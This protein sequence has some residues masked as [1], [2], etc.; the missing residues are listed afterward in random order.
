MSHPII[1]FFIKRGCSI[2]V[3]T[4]LFI[5]NEFVDS[6]D[7]KRFETINPATEKV[8]T[9]VAEALGNDVDRAVDAATE[10]Y[11]NVWKK[12]D[13]SERGR[14]LNKLADLLE[15]DAEEIA[16]LE[17]LDNGKAFS[18]AKALD[19]PISVKAFRYFAGYADKI[20][21]KVMLLYAGEISKFDF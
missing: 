6:I 18:T 4:C 7:G 1:F 8:I 20:H 14:L 15:R 21:G 9:T 13:G 10:A 2:I 3:N 17:S 11:N 12:V 16:S 5:N 19:L